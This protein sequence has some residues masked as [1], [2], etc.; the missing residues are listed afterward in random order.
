ME[1]KKTSNIEDELNDILE[2]EKNSQ[3][4]LSNEEV[5][6][7][8]INLFKKHYENIEDSIITEEQETKIPLP[9][10]QPGFRVPYKEY[11]DIFANAEIHKTTLKDNY[12]YRSFKGN[13]GGVKIIYNSKNKEE[14]ENN[15]KLM[16]E[17]EN[18]G[19]SYIFLKKFTKDRM[20]SIADAKPLKKPHQNNSN[21]S[22][23]KIEKQLIQIEKTLEKTLELQ[24]AL[25]EEVRGKNKKGFWRRLFNF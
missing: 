10:E 15:I 9:K 22:I 5:K 17:Y 8:I 4:P 3:E 7:K 21:I 20:V 23:D 19:Q 11:G 14:R 12:I 25:L 13:L 18:I 24:E 2:K 6:D 1:N 16:T